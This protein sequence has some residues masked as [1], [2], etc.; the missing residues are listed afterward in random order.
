MKQKYLL[1]SIVLFV[2]LFVFISAFSALIPGDF[3]SVN[4]GPPDGCVDFEDLMIFA[5]AYGS[6]AGDDNWNEACDI[7]GPGEIGRAHV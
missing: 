6:S 1:S 2:L 4:N 7:A 3:G 5:I